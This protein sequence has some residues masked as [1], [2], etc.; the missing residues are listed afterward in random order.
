[1]QRLIQSKIKKELAEDILF[2]RLA[3]NGGVVHVVVRAGDL[4]LE[5]DEPVSA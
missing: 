1:M 5:I 2:G 3:N 4:V